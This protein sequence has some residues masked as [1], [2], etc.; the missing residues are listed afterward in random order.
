MEDAAVQAGS[1][2]G[3]SRSSQT[4]TPSTPR[5]TKSTT[6]GVFDLLRTQSLPFDSQ[7]W[8]GALVSSKAP[9]AEFGH[10][11]AEYGLTVSKLNFF[12][13]ND[14]FQCKAV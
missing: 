3:K 4:P 9:M 5:P 2:S 10:A 13:R 11:A 12:A 1:F 8:L 7:E 14:L 6:D